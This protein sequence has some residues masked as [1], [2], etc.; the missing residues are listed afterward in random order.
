M[1]IHTPANNRKSS[2]KTVLPIVQNNRMS[3][4]SHSMAHSMNNPNNMT[5]DQVKQ[6]KQLTVKIAL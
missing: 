4:R 1:I 2:N 5:K 6:T 3:G